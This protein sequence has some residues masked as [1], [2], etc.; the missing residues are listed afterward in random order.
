MT[1]L[2]ILALMVAAIWFLAA[3]GRKARQREGVSA[4]SPAPRA[5]PS[6]NGPNKLASAVE[7]A[8]KAA[9]EEF[10]RRERE[11]DQAVDLKSAE[12]HLNSLRDYLKKADAESLVASFLD[13]TRYWHAWLS[14]KDKPL[15]YLATE[16]F[17]ISDAFKTQAKEPPSAPPETWGFKLA[18]RGSTHSYR[19]TERRSH[20]FMD[21]DVA[22]RGEFEVMNDEGEV[23]FKAPITY[24]HGEYVSHYGMS[25]YSLEVCKATDW[26]VDIAVLVETTRANTAARF[27][28]SRR[29]NAVRR[30]AQTMKVP[31]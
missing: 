9:K 4:P 10:E 29:D 31:K 24:H 8:R 27:K 6:Q 5:Q 21:D 18:H 11:K 15:D 22:K 28:D 16:G 19:V 1:A 7:N 13:T 20:G 2:I 3:K 12:A 14:H 17:T 25:L 26:L 30:A 23:V